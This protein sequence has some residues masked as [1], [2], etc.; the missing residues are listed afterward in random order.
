[1]PLYTHVID[2]CCTASLSRLPCISS[3]TGFILRMCTLMTL[4]DARTW[5]GRDQG[6]PTCQTSKTKMVLFENFCPQTHPT[7][8]SNRTT[9]RV[10]I[11][12]HVASETQPTCHAGH[13]RHVCFWAVLRPRGSE[14]LV[15]EMVENLVVV[16]PN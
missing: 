15:E 3:R 14:H 16:H 9:K 5:S 6:E 8:C 13:W 7:G 2:G 10:Y 4:M 11:A 1:M 12:P